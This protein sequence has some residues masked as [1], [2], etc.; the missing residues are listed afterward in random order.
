MSPLNNDAMAEDKTEDDDDVDLK[1][2]AEE[3]RTLK[4]MAKYWAGINTVSQLAANLGSLGKW[5]MYIY[6]VYIAVKLG[7]LDRFLVGDK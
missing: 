3:I 1:L 2:S 4:L 7:V 6:A 5:M